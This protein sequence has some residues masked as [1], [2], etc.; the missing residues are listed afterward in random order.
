MLGVDIMLIAVVVVLCSWKLSSCW[1]SLELTLITVTMLVL[2][3]YFGQQVA[4]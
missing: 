3:H 1:L 2:Q 4:S